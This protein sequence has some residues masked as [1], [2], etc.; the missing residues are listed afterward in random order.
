MFVP[1]NNLASLLA[2]VSHQHD[3][4]GITFITGADRET[5][6]SYADLYYKALGALRMLQAYGLTPG[7]E[8]VIQ[9]EDNEQFLIIFWACLLGKIIPVPLS[10]GSQSDHRLK[11]IKVWETLSHP[12]WAG[13]AAGLRRLESFADETGR[14]RWGETLRA[15]ALLLEDLL[16]EGHE[17]GQ[18][19]PAS[20]DD[21][22]YVQYSSGSTGEPKGVILTHRNLMAN[23]R[24]IADRSVI[25]ADDVM[26]SWMP[27]THD[28]GMICFHLTGVLSRLNQCVLPTSLFIRRP[29]LW[30]DKASQH[31][32]SLLY[33]PNFGYQYFLSAFDTAIVDW[34]LSAVRLIYNGAEPISRPLCEQFLAALAPFGLQ[35]RTMYPGYGLAE[36]SVAVTLPLPGVPLREYHLNRALLG[37]GDSVVED[38]EDGVS[39]LEVGQAVPNCQVRINGSDGSD[40]PDGVIGHIQIQ[41]DNVTTGYYNKAEA[42][43]TLFTADGWLRTGDLGFLNADRLVITGRAKN[44]IIINGL[45]YYPQDFERICYAIEGAELGKTA[46]CAIP[47]T[48]NGGDDL[49][50]FV[51][52]KGALA[53]FVPLAKRIRQRITEAA[54]VLVSQVVPVRRIPKTTSGKVQYFD[55]VEQYKTGQFSTVVNDL[56]TLLAVDLTAKA[57]L[58][59]EAHLQAVWE[60]LFGSKI[61]LDDDWISQGINSLQ[62]SQL[63]A[64]LNTSLLATLSV[65]DLFAFPSVRQ[66]A[67]HLSAQPVQIS[68]PSL[69]P[70]TSQPYYA[71]T[72][73]QKRFWLL[74]LYAGS[75]SPSCLTTAYQLT[76]PLQTDVLRAALDQLI[77]RHESLRTAFTVVDGE[78]I[79]RVYAYV[80]G[81]AIF[82]EAD[83]RDQPDP[84]RTATDAVAETA[85]RPFDLSAGAPFR[86]TLFRTEEAGYVLALT[87]HHMVADGW[88]VGVFLRELTELYSSCLNGQPTQMPTL[89][90]QFRDY[91]TWR[92][93]QLDS[94]KTRIQRSY[95][96]DTFNDAPTLAL[97]IYGL[98]PVIPSF[99]GRRIVRPLLGEVVTGLHRV[100]REHGSTLFMTLVSVLN[101]LFYK[102]T[103]QTDIVM[104]TDAAGRTHQ[105]LENQIGLYLDTL[106]LRT[107]FDARESFSTL[108]KRVKKEILAAFDLQTYAFDHPQAGLPSTGREPLFNVLV[109]LQNLGQESFFTQLA[110][111]VTTKP[112]DYEITTSLVDLHLE[113]VERED[114]LTLNL[115]YNTDIFAHEQMERFSTHFVRLAGLVATH[116]EWPLADFSLLSDTETSRL[117]DFNA[118][119]V[120][121]CFQTV[122]ER[123][124]TQGAQTPNALAV[125]CGQTILTY[126]QLNQAANKLAHLLLTKYGLTPGDRVALLLPP[127][128]QSVVSLLAVLK[129]SGTYVPLDLSFPQARIASI[130]AD[131]N[132]KLVLT[133]N[134]SR[135]FLPDT[136]ADVVCLEAWADQLT[137]FPSTTPSNAIA[138]TDL[139]YILY[140]SGS[141][142]RPK[143]VLVEHGSLTDYVTTFID[144]FSLQADD[145]VIQQA[146]YAFDTVIEELFPAL[147]VGGVVAVAPGGGKDI[148]GL[149]KTIETQSATVL[150]TTP[151]VL[152]ELN[153]QAERLRGLKLIISG[154]D[155]LRP[156][157]VDRLIGVTAVYNTYGPTE[158]TVCTT[159]NRLTN[160]KEAAIIGTPITNRR[161][162][163]LNDV[164]ELLP[165]GAT[166]EICIAG[167][168]LARGYLNNPSETAKRFVQAH[169]I[170]ERLYRTGDLGRWLP[171]GRIEFL[172]RMDNQ[173]KVRGYRVEP[174]EIEM[175]LLAHPNV[176]EAVVVMGAS[177][178]GGSLV[179]YYTGQEVDTTVLKNFLTAVLPTYLLP[180][181]FIHLAALPRTATG[182]VDRNSLINREFP[183]RYAPFVAPEGPLEIELA[184]IWRIVLKRDEVGSTDDF[185]ALGGDSIKATR[186]VVSI[187]EA[188][189]T[190][191][192][193][194]DLFSQ[195]TLR[196]VATLI[197]KTTADLVET[198]QPVDAHDEYEA[199]RAQGRMWVLSQ[200]ETIGSAYHLT[201]ALRL[202]GA[203]RV[204]LL[205]TALTTLVERHES[206]RTTF[207]LHEGILRQ[208]VWDVTELYPVGTLPFFSNLRDN[209]AEVPM[210]IKGFFDAPFDLE[211]GPLLRVNVLQVTDSEYLLLQSVHHIVMDGWSVNIIAD[212]LVRLYNAALEGRSEALAPLPIQYKDFAAWHHHLLR[213]ETLQS[214]R[215]YWL[216]QFAGEVPVLELPTDFPRPT[217]Q[218]YRGG[219][220]TI[221]FTADEKEQLVTVGRRQGA[222]LFMTLM[223][224]VIALFNRYSGQEDIVVGVPV[225]GRTHRDL[226]GQV[227]N[228][229]NTLP[230]RTRFHGEASFDVLLAGVK[231][232]LLGA[233]ENQLY[234]FDLLV[235][236]LHLNRDT[237]RSPLFDVMVGFQDTATA[238][239]QLA[240]LHKVQAE[241]YPY[242]TGISQFDCSIDF[243]DTGAGLTMRL[244]YN[245]D[246]FKPAWA[247]R[248][249][250]HFV[251]LLGSVIQSPATAVLDLRY[252]DHQEET[253][254]L[255]GFKGP[256]VQLPPDDTFL[257]LFAEQV[258]KTPASVAVVNGNHSLT[259]QQLDEAANQFAH[260]LLTECGVG[261]EE[262]VGVLVDRTEWMV[263]WLLGIMK[264][265]AAYLPI[266]P[267]YPSGRVRHLI[268]DSGVR[269]LVTSSGLATDVDASGLIV[270]QEAN[271]KIVLR[272]YP[273][274]APPVSIDA[275]KLVYVI[276]TSATT[277]LPKGVLVEHGNLA[278][279]A[280]GWKR[281]Y[282]LKTFPVRLLQVA[283]IAFDVFTG[284]LCRALLSGGQL[285]ICPLD[286]RFDYEGLYR[287]IRSAEI[288]TWEATPALVVPFVQYAQAN[289]LDLTFFKLLIVGS[290]KLHVEDYGQLKQ[291]VGA[292]GRVIN[293]YGTTETTIDSSFYEASETETLPLRGNVPIGK[294]FFNTQYYI[295]DAAGHPVPAGVTG[296]LYIGG[297]G[298]SRGYLG[299]P[300]LTQ[301]RF[302]TNPY[303]GGR[304]YRTGD[305]ARGLPGGNVEFLGRNDQQ[306]KIRGYRVELGEIENLLLQY[307]GVEAAVVLAA[308]NGQGENQ[309]IAYLVAPAARL[310]Q[311]VQLHLASY[312]P[313]ALVPTQII[314]LD[315]M[316]LTPNGKLDRLGLP[317]PVWH[318]LAPTGQIAPRTPLEIK[319][320]NIWS[321]VLGR[322]DIGVLDNFFQI[323]GHSLKATQL[324]WRIHNDLKVK[325]A[326]K[327]IFAQP[328]IA[329]LA[330]VVAVSVSET[331]AEIPALT[332]S[333]HYPLSS[334][335]QRLWVIE[336]TRP[337]QTAYSMPAFYEL[338]GY[339]DT[340]ALDQAF[341]V[342]VERHES[343]RTTFLSV[344]AEP[345]Q[346]VQP[347]D[348]I[349]IKV[350]H[351]QM[352]YKEALDAWIAVEVSTPFNLLTGPLIRISCVKLDDRKSMLAV[353]MHHII[354][355]GW[356][357]QVLVNDWVTLY[358]AFS[359]GI[360]H[361]LPPLPIQY[362]EYAAWQL[363]N[364][365]ASQLAPHRAYW[366]EHFRGEIPVLDMPTDY[367]RPSQRTGRGDQVETT[368]NADLVAALVRLGQR[369]E[370]S[371]FMLLL[372]TVKVLLYKYTGQR[373]LVVGTPVAGRDHPSLKNL[374]GFFVNILPLRTQL[375]GEESFTTSLS[376]VKAVTTEAF[377]HQFYPFDHLVD[378]LDQ[379]PKAGHSPLFDVLVVLQNTGASYTL[380]DLQGLTVTERQTTAVASKFD[381]TFTFQEEATGLSLSLDYN[382]DLFEKP[383]MQ[384]LLGHYRHLLSAVVANPDLSLDA[385]E[386]LPTAERDQLLYSFN[387]TDVAYDREQTI[388]RWF[389]TQAARTPAAVAVVGEDASLT[390]QQLNQQAN[391]L[392][393]HLRLTY[394]V[395]ANDRI[396]V[397]LSRS[398][399]LL[400]GILGVLKAGGAY[401]PIDPSYPA[402]RQQYMIDTSGIK[403]LLTDEEVQSPVPVLALTSSF[404]YRRDD[405]LP[406]GSTADDLVYVLYTSGSTGKPKG[407][408]IIHRSV[409]N[410]T[411]WL[412]ATIYQ[413][414]AT[415]LTALLTAS[416][417]FDASV[418]QLFAPL[419]NGGRLV[420]LPEA[421]KQNPSQFLDRLFEHRVNVLDVTPSYLSQLVRAAR[422]RHQTSFLQYV[423]VGGEP[424]AEETVSDFG[425]RFGDCRLI[426]VYG[427]TEA[428]V[429]S[430]YE[431]IDGSRRSKFSIGQ[432]LFN[433]QVYVLD[434]A[435]NLRPIG[436]PGELYIGGDG[437]GRGYL[438]REDLTQARFVENPFAPGQRLYRSGDLGRWTEEG[439][440]EYLG[441]SDNQVKVRGYRIELGEIESVLRKFPAVEFALVLVREDAQTDKQ[442]VAYLQSWQKPDLAELKVL[443]RQ[444]LPDYM[445]PTHWVLLEHLPLTESG[446]LNIKALPD[447]G[448]VPEDD[449]IPAATPLESRLVCIWQDVLGRERIGRYANF[450]ELGGHSLRAMQLATRLYREFDV[451]LD[452]KTLYTHP[453]VVM[454]AELLSR[455][456]RSH[457]D[458]IKALDPQETYVLSHAQ[459]RLWI[460]HQLEQEKM[461]YNV[462]VAYQLH[463]KPDLVELNRVF[464]T[465]ISRHESLRT[466]FVTVNGEPRQR[467]LSPD[468]PFVVNYEES[469][470]GDPGEE[471]VRE[472]VNT[473]IQTPFDLSQGPLVRATL[474]RMNPDTF[475]FVFNIH[476]IIVDAWSTEVL[477]REINLLYSAYAVDSAPSL[478]SLSVQYRDF[479]AWQNDQL[480]AEKLATHQSYWHEKLGGDLPVLDLPTDRP[481][482]S[483]KTQRGSTVKGH[484]RA[485]LA[486]P[487]KQLSHREGVS[488]FNTLLALVTLLLHRYT[489]KEDIIVGA[490]MAGR[491]H[492]QLEDQIGLYV[493]TMPLRTIFR[494]D[495]PFGAL[496]DQVKDTL[497]SAYTHQLYP[498]DLLVENLKVPRDLSR[499]PLFDVMVVMQNTVLPGQVSTLTL[500]GVP[501]TAYPLTGTT[502]KF[503]LVFSF[504]DAG[505]RIGLEVEFNTDLYDV[506]TIERLIGH[507]HGL[508]AAVVAETGN[509]INKLSYMPAVEQQQVLVGF[510]DNAVV[511]P[512]DA[513]IHRLFEEQV[514]RT[515]DSVAVVYEDRHLTYAELNRKA[516]Q[517]AHYLRANWEIGPDDR[518]G[519][520]LE[521][522]EWVM[523]GILGVLKA[524]GAYVPIDPAYP[525]ERKQF[526]IVDSDMHVLLTESGLRGDLEA[527]AEV[528]LHNEAIYAGPDDNLAPCSG[529]Q[530]V[531][532][533]IYTSGTTGMP[534]GVLI[535]HRSVVNLSDW[536]SNLIYRQTTRS[537][538]TLLTA[539]IS[540]DS[541]VKQLFAP[542]LNGSCLVF[543]ADHKK[544][545]PRLFV[546]ELVRY[547]VDVLDV[548]PSY[549]QLL[550]AYLPDAVKKPTIRYTLVGGEMLSQEV[551][552]QYYDVLGSN[553]RLVNVYGITE[554]T[555]D[556]TFEVIDPDSQ[557][558][559]S[560]GRTLQNTAVHILDG[561]MGLVPVGVTGEMY[562]AGDGLAREYLNR[563]ELTAR[564]FIANPYL[565]GTRLYRSGDLGRWLTDGRIDWV[566]RLDTQ[567]K[568]RG[569][570]IE[571][572]EIENNLLGYPGVDRA[573]VMSRIDPTGDPY[574]AAYVVGL[575]EQEMGSLKA[576]LAGRLPAHMLPAYVKSLR[577]IPL[578][579]HGKVD[580]RQL[581]NPEE[582]IR[583]GVESSLPPINDTQMAI[584]TV[585][586]QVLGQSSI[587][588]Q[589]NFFDLGGNSLK[590]IQAYAILNK[591]FPDMIQVHDLFSHPTVEKL[592]CL[593]NPG[594]PLVQH[595][596]TIN[597]VKF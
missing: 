324:I 87:F 129:A 334:A 368:L 262:L 494:G 481:R 428:T 567:V 405:N 363:A 576:Y 187:E 117:L 445:L 250:Q 171:D 496:L 472:R 354:S 404:I 3:Q 470:V 185:F 539:S 597:K 307:P 401:V 391:Q 347:A 398:S 142:G 27:L 152:N 424:L 296:E 109:I 229:L 196:Q 374:V 258:I 565:P 559:P 552:Q 80:S 564:Q 571:L 163:I 219:T 83:L 440:L 419:V 417:N 495:E 270:L 30:M 173:L 498:F 279:I 192:S 551:S 74:D 305:L 313:E 400:V 516:N 438:N 291:A 243:F 195:P 572:G 36:A 18:V 143:G 570:R 253:Q 210:L 224:S 17:P 95:W 281:F 582:M 339:L 184:N 377:E 175:A 206:L 146:S 541:S 426:N 79:Q 201:W 78:L 85:S 120:V 181:Y 25:R 379:P 53:D 492:L 590:V 182:K 549:L 395:G 466:V 157:H 4:T 165:E 223:A 278:T 588:R 317:A 20:P 125:T 135:Q 180:G 336:Q 346:R 151:L 340:T 214:Q 423:L 105:A 88:S 75:R 200:F 199:S 327:T 107:R 51:L 389:E 123:I 271:L 89:T 331:L 231:E 5:F 39:F 433:T 527:I 431:I 473:I 578:T 213:G 410:L 531:M 323:G 179:A 42:S 451:E 558:R 507:L 100:S 267:Q 77:E 215:T 73:A 384:R 156:S 366:E 58:S 246:L 532:Y 217:L 65:K 505:D 356:S 11:V 333:E 436:V 97:P 207:I 547:R 268:E 259:Y 329:Q 568:I 227:G 489:G 60:A 47:N 367:P 139:A 194:R 103:G 510:N 193:I 48:Q 545:D 501:I 403:L 390:Y 458:D 566:G 150:S 29:V 134:R 540:F 482:P 225:A 67:D 311:P 412:T 529:A 594:E 10:A 415:P 280:Q 421:S 476:H 297:A 91:V 191:I 393:W 12:C 521:R 284:D 235:E 37:V 577:S 587:Q 513:T 54:S 580:Y 381:L 518:V 344:G 375:G 301:E 245:T 365:T 130:M 286:L 575:S 589:D 561:Q 563:K 178:V 62:A 455:A 353:N 116:A 524:G 520:M 220:T 169:D 16:L 101:V 106:L 31:R 425:Q 154:G 128:E 432:P 394:S 543:L 337:G 161:V 456:V 300:A 357:V 59:L 84:Y 55:L 237:S 205:T 370:V 166:G 360:A 462:P 302:L 364:L 519:L 454:Q 450:F 183:I 63:T 528:D 104:G 550:L 376:R 312:M 144:Y 189:G 420:L 316:P 483:V 442:L 463:G 350:S 69:E 140:T 190:R 32:A 275:T 160:P 326:I 112:F 46:A 402:E 197:G 371:L 265:G 52:Y 416:I 530:N 369:Q 411:H 490:P 221:T 522:S 40:Y 82:F 260:Y 121:R 119:S 534:K 43:A 115:I 57:D 290:D 153:A 226:V 330:E 283:S 255:E 486:D 332:E 230:V 131:A 443:A 155:V 256:S 474:L 554:A 310:A 593:L 407:V 488:L 306:V 240:H 93:Q 44:L 465:I 504:T 21:I 81:S 581:P 437:V 234:P 298:V 188:F 388:H 560:I 348:S 397:M 315:R 409:V 553:S 497:L 177:E 138:P 542:L 13:D 261:S 159:F 289:G 14:Q 9:T 56:D 41:G 448:N 569:F 579:V 218:T 435:R 583:S 66:L 378:T 133:D 509:A 35:S 102:Y 132:C 320:S 477:V 136:S 584:A 2:G 434:A 460:L 212:E 573:V 338:E 361:P 90:V 276:Y 595:E 517:V 444:F 282:D 585:W 172:G 174:G 321:D 484:F 596:V 162:Y 380:A 574:L 24:A 303:H 535:E 254:L 94:E 511:Y 114:N 285:V 591:Q 562:I 228:Y 49:V 1:E 548:T 446:K 113:F 216:E 304:M 447:P 453:T 514:L 204:D 8:L 479:A 439:N 392:A 186:L 342:L 72:E 126:Y 251:T 86:V 418:Q 249:I 414:H 288:N 244:E 512:T 68:R 385:L 111:G 429:D 168:G 294:P 500:D 592:A 359:T 457:Y 345:R 233:Y 277:G 373:D 538:V 441:R 355:D 464:R 208:R 459:Q 508:A 449:Y 314:F 96:L 248:F 318:S 137:S 236:D 537:L 232:S 480:T 506:S 503:D 50:I 23:V 263:I 108:L 252:L 34:N 555:V 202:R 487:L 325:L 127:S 158:S 299:R 141:T 475:V 523:V 343:L 170:G 272:D 273:T 526:I 295:L 556:T 28:M 176:Q 15:Q 396:G 493:N 341:Q 349:D 525:K 64:R 247:D 242:E 413:H 328:T 266:D 469:P 382:A 33:S 478:P 485:E 70:T 452:L 399:R 149:L 386:Y 358:N 533:V 22:A 76:G 319:L 222:S 491:P 309:L 124:E 430:T 198:I 122:T 362:K 383:R 38:I 99:R 544:K 515:P 145:T 499:S 147:C 308:D 110:G 546:E 148:A 406:G 6:L 203:L 468:V 98:R 61:G 19:F 322:Q 274:S 238:M 471:W 351:L 293:S 211:N 167:T 372:T 269:L 26:L 557:Q 118:P 264:A 287:L 502:A 335:Q 241:P 422:E 45:N 164:L 536:L 427:I 467:I 7:R 292:G 92:H 408:Q 71:T 239:S 352:A 209:E 387:Q 461:S 257:E 586:Q